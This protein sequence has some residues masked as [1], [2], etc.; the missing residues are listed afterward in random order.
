MSF[1]L[2]PTYFTDDCYAAVICMW[3]AGSD[4]IQSTQ[5]SHVTCWSADVLAS[6]SCWPVCVCLAA[7]IKWRGSRLQCLLFMA[8]TTKWLISPTVVPSTSAVRTPSIHCGSTA[9]DTTTSSILTNTSSDS[10]DLSASTFVSA[11]D[12][13]WHAVD[14]LY[15]RPMLHV[16]LSESC[17][18][19]VFYISLIFPLY[20]R[21][22]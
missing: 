21:D 10:H 19:C 15:S 12:C 11:S 4:S 6:G 2:W 7:L 16:W 3:Q 22:L 13:L 9:R 20:R 17:R 8:R 14:A 1:R 5:L 18:C